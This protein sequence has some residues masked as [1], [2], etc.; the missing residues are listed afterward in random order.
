MEHGNMRKYIVITSI[1]N[2]TNAVISFSKKLDYKLVVIGDKKTPADWFCEN[3]RYL[4]IKE[5]GK[6]GKYLNKI[7]PYNHYCRKMIGYLYSIANDADFIIDTDDDNIPNDV[8][9]FPE[10]KETYAVIN[11]GMGFINVYQLYTNMHI[12]PRG[13]PLSLINKRFNLENSIDE[14]CCN[15]GIWQGL[16]D[17]DP[18]VDAIYRLTKNN[19][20]IFNKRNPVVLGKGTIS[21]FNT[22]NTIVTKELFPLMYLPTFVTFRFTDILRGLIAQPIMWLYGYQLGFTNANVVQKRNIHNYF[23]DFLSE[24]PMYKHSEEIVGIASDVITKDDSIQNN[25]FNVYVELHTNNIVESK[26]LV[27]LEAWLKDLDY[28]MGQK[29]CV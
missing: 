27:T 4:S 5:Q 3:A 6:I 22:Q 24:I 25:L 28:I 18:D 10:N 7:L 26:E 19:T 2:P 20:C 9:G 11:E 23:E 8:W 13:L 15:V 16:A 29:V 12:W 14:K 1:N 21:P 17:E